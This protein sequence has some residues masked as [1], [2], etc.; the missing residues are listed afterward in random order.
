[1]HVLPAH[2]GAGV[3]RRILEELERCARAHDVRAVRLDTNARLTEANRMYRE[4]GYV[5]IEDY[6]A[7]PRA[8]RWFEKL[9]A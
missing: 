4:A 2:R 8:D 5:E 7:N 3:A 6:N 9:L 1:M